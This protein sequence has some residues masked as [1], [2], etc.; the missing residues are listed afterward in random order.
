ML[1]KELNLSFLNWMKR[2]IKDQRRM[3]KRNFEKIKN[4]KQLKAIEYQ[5]QRQLDMI[6]EHGRKQL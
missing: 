6:D 5:G 2:L 3:I 4:K 1:L